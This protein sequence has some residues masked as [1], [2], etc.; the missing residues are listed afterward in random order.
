MRHTLLKVGNHDASYSKDGKPVASYRSTRKVG[1]HSSPRLGRAKLAPVILRTVC[2]LRRKA[3]VKSPLY[4]FLVCTN[5][6]SFFP[7]IRA[8]H[9]IFAVTMSQIT[10][11]KINTAESVDD[12]LDLLPPN[13]EPSEWDVICQRG[14]ECFEHGKS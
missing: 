6:D 12:N 8:L 14:K 7:Y 1:N 9:A 13:F 2:P 10:H 5:I 11:Q 3:P 4:A